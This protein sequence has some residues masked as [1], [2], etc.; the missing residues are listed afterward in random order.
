M[1]FTTAL[2]HIFVK[3]QPRNLSKPAL[4]AAY[5]SFLMKP[6]LLSKQWLPSGLSENVV[7]Y[8]MKI[9]TEHVISIGVYLFFQTPRK[10][11]CFEF[12]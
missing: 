3:N 1:Q 10:I 9:P 4:F 5:Y 11:I 8:H 12:Y 6:R 7:H 2:I